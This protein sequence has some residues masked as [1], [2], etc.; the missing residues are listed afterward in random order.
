MPL[1]RSDLENQDGPRRL[2]TLEECEN[3]YANGETLRERHD[4]LDQMAAFPDGPERLV[5]ILCDEDTGKE[6]CAYVIALLEKVEGEEAPIHDLMPLL[7]LENAYVRNAAISILQQYGEAI[8]EHIVPYL[9]GED[10]DAKIL[11]INVLGDVRFPRSRELLARVLENE[12]DVNV[13]MTAVDYLGEIGV[14]G[15]IP[16]LE[17][18][19]RRFSHEP[20]AAFAVKRVIK[21][22]RG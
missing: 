18:V 15:D 19:E 3:V 12:E 6:T 22:I 5:R 20:F 7:K 4:A 16:L 1:I 9:E 2:A 8:I 21:A 10:R 13:V 14:P 17:E 11:A